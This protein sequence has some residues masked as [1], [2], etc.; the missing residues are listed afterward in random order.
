MSNLP[1]QPGD[2]VTVTITRLF[3]GGAL[4]VT[5][6]DRPGMLLDPGT[7]KAGDRVT[8]T[9]AEVDPDTGRFNGTAAG[10]DRHRS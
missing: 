4:V 8:M 2:T 3:A 9:I 1:P 10:N 5:D 6:D 7:A